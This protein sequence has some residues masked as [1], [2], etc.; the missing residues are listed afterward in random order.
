MWPG[1]PAPTSPSP[2]GTLRPP[3]APRRGADV[4]CSRR[5]PPRTQQ[6]RG[7][8]PQ[9]RRAPLPP[10]GDWLRRAPTARPCRRPVG[11]ERCPSA[12]RSALRVRHGEAGPAV[13]GRAMSAVPRHPAAPQRYAYLP[14]GKPPLERR[15]RWR[16]REM[17]KETDSTLVARKENGAY[18]NPA[19]RLLP[20]AE[21]AGLSR[22]LE[23]RAD[24][25]C[26]WLPRR[27]GS[28]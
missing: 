26:D 18:E 3:A 4:T 8:S 12:L 1:L 2:A 28:G 10:P 16:Q 27:A 21:G 13:F 22:G 17:A 23:R 14:G 6:R 15:R 24:R 7:C 9:G 11:E 19:W 20:G 5:R 25:G